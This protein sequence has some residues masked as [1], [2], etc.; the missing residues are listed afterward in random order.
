[1]TAPSVVATAEADEG[2]VG[3]TRMDVGEGTVDAKMALDRA[4]ETD[5]A[6]EL[7]ADSELDTAELCAGVLGVS[8]VLA[9]EFEPLCLFAMWTSLDAIIGFSEWTCSRA[10]R[11]LLNT[12]SLN[13]GERECRAWWIASPSME[14]RSALNSSQSIIAA[15]DFVCLMEGEEHAARKRVLSTSTLCRPTMVVWCV[16]AGRMAEELEM[17][18]EN[19]G[20]E[21]TCH[22]AGLWDSRRMQ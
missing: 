12:P 1:M 7:D 21:R 9:V 10:E 13:L 19:C 6:L 18:E 17:D 3:A 8:V 5:A 20:N 22:N 16:R 11:S 15:A 2:V 4:E 14:S